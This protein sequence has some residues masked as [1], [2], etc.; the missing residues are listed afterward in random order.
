MQSNIPN[1]SSEIFQDESHEEEYQVR[2]EDFSH[3]EGNYIF[4][5]GNVSSGK[6]TLQNILVYR[7]CQKDNVYF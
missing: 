7:L 2:D 3:K 4:T 5:V 6:S 1:N